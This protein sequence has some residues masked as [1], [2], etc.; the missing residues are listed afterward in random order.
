MVSAFARQLT[1]DLS[2]AESFAREDFF[3][4]PS[5]AA[6]LRLIERWPDWPAPVLAH[7]SGPVLRPLRRR[8]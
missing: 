6:A 2:H 4:A 3:P 7:W 1:L 8:R 5:N